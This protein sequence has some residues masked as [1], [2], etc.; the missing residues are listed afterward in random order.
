MAVEYPQI[1]FDSLL[2]DEPK[3]DTGLETRP[4]IDF[5]A[6]LVEPELAS[7]RAVTS[8]YVDPNSEAEKVVLARK[9]QETFNEDW[10]PMAVDPAEARRR[11]GIA[12]NERILSENPI[13]SRKFTDSTFANITHKD[14]NNLGSL[15]RTV[16]GT[17]GD[18]GVTAVKGIIGLPQFAVGL[19][20]IPTFGY[21]GKGLEAIGID[22][23]E[24]QDILDTMYSPAQQAANR[25]VQQ[26]EGFIDTLTAAAQNP[27][28]ILTTVGESLPSMFAGGAI[29]RAL[30]GAGSKVLG[31]GMAGPTLPGYLARVLGERGAGI[32]AGAAGE[33]LVTAG[34]MAEQIRAESEEGLLTGKQALASLGAGFGTGVIGA[35]GGKAAQKL[36]LTDI[37]TLIAEGGEKAAQAS[38]AKTGFMRN[39]IGSGIAEGVFEELPQSA[40]EQMWQN[41]AQDRPV[42]EGVGSA[43]AMGFLAGAAT[44]SGAAT[45]KST[46]DRLQQ[47]RQAETMAQRIEQITQLAR[48]SQVLAADPQTFRDFMQDVGEASDIRELF[49][50]ARVL[51]QRISESGVPVQQLEAVMP[52]ITQQITT[53]AALNESV[54]I[55]LADF[56]THIAP[57][58][59][60]DALVPDLRT[61]GGMSVTEAR[62][63]IDNAAEEFRG[64]IETLQTTAQQDATFRK[65]FRAVRDNLEAQVLAASPIYSTQ[66]AR[67]AATLE[68]ARYAALARQL[69]I[70][71]EEALQRFPAMIAREGQAP[72]GQVGS[73]ALH[74]VAIGLASYLFVP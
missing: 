42:L 4:Q 17:L 24:A 31:A 6:L 32:V 9:L 56:A 44:G 12:E 59:L 47:A 39:V 33:G 67:A 35:V 7:S 57:T 74:M 3:L 69:N 36:K 34:T 68:A 18:I 5:N 61:E 45:V 64:A 62:A 46:A 41:W 23:A 20:N 11:L 52:G 16:T 29:G 2:K 73:H 37:D 70:T 55:P 21:A 51:A 58:P 19:A 60:A 8:S 63:V 71:P 66:D 26:A 27:S 54:A 50:D 30:L 49:V 14:L 72:G 28:T 13:L 15:E 22:M 38:V 10:S 40:Q 1:D 53:A 48:A 65:S 43:A 25:R